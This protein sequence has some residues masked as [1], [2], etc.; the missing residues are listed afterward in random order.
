MLEAL[1]DDAFE[2][3][4]ERVIARFAE[5]FPGKDIP[6]REVAARRYLEKLLPQGPQ[7]P[8][9]HLHRIVLDGEAVGT[10]WYAEQLDE[11]PPRVFLYDI[12]VDEDHRGKGL[13]TAAMHALEEEGRRLG[14]KQ[15]MLAVFFGN[16]GAIRLY[17]RLGFLPTERGEAGMRM[18]KPL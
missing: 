15:V 12:E 7:T 16:P 9:Q 13:G 17:E 2:A 4:R 18:A 11:T 5:S 3:Y 6:Q 14:A 10:L 1:P 8:G